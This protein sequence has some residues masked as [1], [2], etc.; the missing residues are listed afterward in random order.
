[1]S[2]H[3]G[4]GGVGRGYILLSLPYKKGQQSD[5]EKFKKGR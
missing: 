3:K 1:M 2:V 4:E 5:D